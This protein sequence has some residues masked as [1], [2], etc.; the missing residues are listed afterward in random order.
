[1]A[2]RCSSLWRNKTR[3][4]LKSRID[5]HRPFSWL[6]WGF[7]VSSFDGSKTSSKTRNFRC[8]M[9]FDLAVVPGIALWQRPPSSTAAGKCWTRSFGYFAQERRGEIV[10]RTSA[11]GR[12]LGISST[13]GPKTVPLLRSCEDFDRWQSRTHSNQITFGAQTVL[14]FGLLDVVLAGKK[15]GA[16]RTRR[17]CIGPL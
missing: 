16:S 12:R 3:L 7:L 14:R 6:G 15:T 1:M 8:S 9:G 10:Q 2:R 4:C 11:H 5:R 17:S 13:S